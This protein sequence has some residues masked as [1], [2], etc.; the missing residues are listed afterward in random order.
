MPLSP[1]VRPIAGDVDDELV[2]LGAS[3]DVACLR[4]GLMARLGGWEIGLFSEQDARRQI[5][6]CGA[7]SLFQ[8]HEHF[9]GIGTYTKRH[10]A[11]RGWHA[12]SLVP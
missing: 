5:T 4:S 10:D 12:A 1:A 9:R 3:P 7:D 11:A 8:E 6:A 2:T